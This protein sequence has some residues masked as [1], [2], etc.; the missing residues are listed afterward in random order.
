MTQP[1]FTLNETKDPVRRMQKL[2]ERRQHIE[3]TIEQL[4]DQHFIIEGEIAGLS[5]EC[6]R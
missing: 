4:Q 3:D 1:G 2:H 5:R 6:P